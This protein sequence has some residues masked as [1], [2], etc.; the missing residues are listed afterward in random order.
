MD[1]RYPRSS[2]SDIRGTLEAWLD[3]EREGVVHKARGVSDAAGA[4]SPLAS[5]TSIT[6]LVGHLAIVEDYW[7]E[8]AMGTGGDLPSD[9][10]FEAAWATTPASSLDDAIEE[11]E[12]ACARSRNVQSK[13][14]TLDQRAAHPRMPD[15]TYGWVLTHMIEET[16][17]HLGH[18]DVL[19][20]LSDGTVGQ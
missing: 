17:R 4:I 9:A 10:R 11:F 15:V 14:E 20:E 8:I 19:R 7:F 16:A 18:I 6:G 13:V 5:G 3:Y 1:R 2:T 12:A